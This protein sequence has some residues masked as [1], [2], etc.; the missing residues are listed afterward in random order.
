M[1]VKKLVSIAAFVVLGLVVTLLAPYASAQTTP[2]EGETTPPTTTTEATPSARC[3]AIKKNLATRLT[4]VDIAKTAQV[5][6][7]EAEQTKID[8]L[9]TT[10]STAGYDVTAL[11]TAQG[12][13]KA[14]IT[15]FN[16]KA[17]V[18]STALTTAQ[19]TEC[20]SDETAMKKAVVD[21]RTALVAVR[22]ASQDVR[23]AFKDSV[24]TALKDYIVWLKTQTNSRE[25]QK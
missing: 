16:D 24:I 8:T 22:T 13:V 10:A 14:K 17:T 7:Y 18:Y 15:T 1:L 12:V 25:A 11:T 20:M 21:A 6:V 4:K 9:L 19:N 2:T 23:V 3:T 5:K